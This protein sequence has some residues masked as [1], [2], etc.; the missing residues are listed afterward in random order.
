M[1]DACIRLIKSLQ[2]FEIIRVKC[3]CRALLTELDEGNFL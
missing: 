1:I 3:H 2:K